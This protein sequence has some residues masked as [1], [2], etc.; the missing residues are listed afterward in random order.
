MKNRAYSATVVDVFFCIF[1]KKKN[2]SHNGSQ[3]SNNGQN[4]RELC[5]SLRELP[6]KYSPNFSDYFAED[7]SIIAILKLKIIRLFIFFPDN[8]RPLIVT[9]TK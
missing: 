4:F 7:I 3:Y 1:Q 6:E 2:V 5:E 9:G 8:L